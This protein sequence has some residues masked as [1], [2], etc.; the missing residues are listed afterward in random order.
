MGHGILE[1]SEKAHQGKCCSRNPER[2]NVWED[3]T[4][5]GEREQGLKQELRLRSKKTLFEVL[6]Q[7]HVLVVVK[8]VVRISIRLQKVSDWTLW[9]G[10][11]PPK[12]H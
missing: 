11:S 2:M 7:T 10:W 4:N 1:P 8:Q 6:G 12:V 5:T 3:T 9:R